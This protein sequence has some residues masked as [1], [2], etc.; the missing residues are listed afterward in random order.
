MGWLG[1]RTRTTAAVSLAFMLECA[2]TVACVASL[3]RDFGTW[4]F[5]VVAAMLNVADGH[6]MVIAVS[7][8]LVES[9]CAAEGTLL[10]RWGSNEGRISYLGCSQCGNPQLRL[11]PAGARTS[12]C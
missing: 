11:W 1:P 9:C 5:C 2:P 12:G 3:C 7:P 4:K 6:H 10:N 8:G